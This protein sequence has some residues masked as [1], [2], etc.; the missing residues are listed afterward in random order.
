MSPGF[1]RRLERGSPLGVARRKNGRPVHFFHAVILHGVPR[2]P[3]RDNEAIGILDA[4]Q[5]WLGWRYPAVEEWPV[6][7]GAPRLG[8]ADHTGRFSGKS[9]RAA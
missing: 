9:P 4:S 3:S 8:A 7:W 6:Q 2:Q 1:L 5:V